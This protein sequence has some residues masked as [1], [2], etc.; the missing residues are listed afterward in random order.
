[1]AALVRQATE[2]ADMSR[3]EGRPLCRRSQYGDSGCLSNLEVL[4]GYVS[5][6]LQILG[7][8]NDVTSSD[9][10]TYRQDSLRTGRHQDSE[11]RSS[12]DKRK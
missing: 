10:D 5:F 8:V 7:P 9:D 2:A 1:V 4:P 12:S 3:H 11:H 6:K